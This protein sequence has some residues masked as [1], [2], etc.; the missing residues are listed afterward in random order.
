MAASMT[1][2][3]IYLERGGDVSPVSGSRHF[4]WNIP[5]DLLL[6]SKGRAEIAVEQV[7]GP[8]HLCHV[9]GILANANAPDNSEN[10]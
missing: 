7:N 8:L 4:R 1:R 9:S 10:R 5:V 2:Q 3:S 6:A